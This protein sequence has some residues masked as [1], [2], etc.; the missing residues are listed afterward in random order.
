MNEPVWDA[1][2]ALLRLS[3]PYQ[4]LLEGGR[5]TRLPGAAAAWVTTL[6]AQ[7][8]ARPVLVVAPHEPAALAWVEGAR[9]AGADVAFFPVS[10]LTPYQ[11]AEAALSERVQQVVALEAWL[12]GAATMMVCTPQALFQRLPTEAGLSARVVELRPGTDLPMEQLAARLVDAGYHRTDLVTEVGEFAVR[13][14]VLDIFAAGP[15]GAVRLDFFGDTLETIR[16][17]DVA[18]QLSQGQLESAS[19]VP[20][21]LFGAGSSQAER[22]LDLISENVEALGYEGRQNLESLRSRGHFAGWTALLPLVSP[23]SES[24]L[25]VSGVVPMVVTIEPQALVDAARVHAD[26]LVTD[27]GVAS[28]DGRFAPPPEEVEWP[29]TTVV[30]LIEDATVALDPLATGAEVIDFACSE[31]DLFIRQLPRFPRE[32]E[33]ARARGERVVLVAGGDRR[34]R[35]E[36][37]LEERSIR[38]DVTLIE[39]ELQRGFR[40]PAAGV[41][42]FGEPQLFVD[43]AP[44]AR[45]RHATIDPFVSGLQDL[46]VGEYV[47]HAE[48]GIGRFVKLRNLSPGDVGPVPLPSSLAEMEIS[49]DTSAEVMEIEYADQRR[50]LLPMSRLDMIERYSG[51]EGIA[52]RLDRLGGSSWTR[53]RDR[54]RAGMRALAIDLRRL[55]AERQLQ[56]APPM[57]ADSDLQQ[58]FETAFEHEETRDQLEATAAIKRDMQ[59]ER[60]MDRLLCGDVGFGK[61]EV[62]MR[63]A[64]KAV[65]SGYQVVVLAPTTILADQHLETF[66]ERLRDFAVK[67]EMI[68]RFRT[69]AEIREVIEAASQGKVDILIGTHRVLSQDIQ[70]PRVGLLIVD[71]E[72]RFGVAQKER[73]KE[74]RKDIHVL[75]MSA[76]PV[77]RTLQLSLAGVRDLSTIETPPRNRMAVETAIVPYNRT[78]V[79]EAIEFELARGG[80]VYYVYNHVEGIE[81]VQESLREIVP[82]ARVT[83]GH[84]QMDERELSSR[85]HAFK[86][87]D[88][89]VLLATTIIENGIDIPS[90]NTMLIHRADRFGLAQLYQLRGRVGRSD[91]LGYCYLMVSP[92]KGLSTVARRRLSAIREF[93]ELG[94]GFRIAAR[95]LEIRGAGNLLG[96]EQSGHMA[97][98]GIETYL[99]MLEETVRELQGE[100]IAEPVSTAIDLPIAMS[101][102][103]DYVADANLRMELYRRIAR[104]SA[105]REKLLEEFTDRFGPPPDEVHR[106]LDVVELKRLAEGLR[107]Q[108]ISSRAGSLHLR[109]RQD[110]AIVVEDLVRLV[111][112]REDLAFSPSG[113]LRIDH[114]KPGAMV[115]SAWELLTTLAG[116]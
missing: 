67:V 105:P 42:V 92:T 112:E 82:Q 65:E 59:L 93:T 20:L 73:F 102:P 115:E 1:A 14:G 6:L 21:T 108:S 68:S 96:A 23:E 11:A 51:I 24:V 45:R 49:R 19:V 66:R 28:E 104:G 17:F 29:L 89:D 41:V 18:S 81:T 35:V 100:T 78:L 91:K 80:Q 12:S 43:V 58:Q 72:Q 84:G 99:K 97:S 5:A 90:V 107:V 54:V 86:R 50:L 60:P 33:T 94:A 56:R 30:D 47:V 109:L 79:R 2:S 74:L 4:A 39:G 34:E 53:T 98:V 76:T 55:Y 106:L 32:I 83:V 111:S 48:H 64:F 101:I 31:T 27:Q 87:G 69:P 110:T 61:T 103:I 37:F 70:L 10:G 77:P 8:L 26:Q 40:L 62:A 13:G 75:A 52:P 44:P 95:D 116:S 85:M 36:S 46:K 15:T 7:D 25:T 71:E 57:A 88:Y 63:A 16:P 9:F 38:S 113:V 114:V 22:L 3:A